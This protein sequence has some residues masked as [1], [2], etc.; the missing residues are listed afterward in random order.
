VNRSFRVAALLLALI[1]A[2]ASL[3]SA[4]QA[5][6]KKAASAQ[7]DPLVGQVMVKLRDATAIERVQKLGAQRVAALSKTAGLALESVRPMS[8]DATVMRLPAAMPLSQAQA[9][10]DRL[11]ADPSVEWAA[12]DLPVRRLQT[13]VPPDQGYATLQWNLFPPTTPFTSTT[14]GGGS[15][16]FIP[17]GG[18]NLPPAWGITTG[19]STITVAVID[20]GVVGSQRDLAGRLLPGF[21]FISSSALTSLGVPENFVANDGNGRDADASDPGDWV[22]ANEKQLYPT[23]CADGVTGDTP[24]SWHGTHMAGIIAALWGNDI[25]PTTGQLYPGTRIA[26]IGPGL[27]ILPVRALGKCGGTSS[28]VIDAMRWAAGLP[29]SSTGQTWAA[30]GIPANTSPA[31]VINLS[32]GGSPIACT[33]GSTYAPVVADVT[34]AGVTIVA[35]SGNDGAIGVLSPANCPGVIAVT[36]HVINGD[37]ADYSNV[38]PEVAI[39]AP[40]GGAPAFLQVVPNLLT[41]DDAYLIWSTGLFGATTPTSTV[42][43]TDLRSGDALVGVTGTSPAT[44]HVSAAVALMLSVNPGLTT[45]NIRGLLAASA[46]PHPTGGYCLTQQ[47]LNQC[48]AGLLDVGVALQR[49][50]PPPPSGGGGGGS[51][52][53]WPVLLM[54]ALGLA[55]EVR[56]RPA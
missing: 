37:N 45:A 55:R 23:A 25:D 17:A 14:V 34:A 1:G 44:P 35:A 41:T 52:P 18:A 29:A 24:S 32:L 47:G 40:G 43:S 22:T 20:T 27:R 50:V 28:D 12:P 5:P 9:V 2:A 30:L 33:A 48:G 8:G 31:K 39:S 7:R 11:R 16:T 26:G 46:R 42:S 56:R 13:Q 54:F 36:A 51:L 6:L 19:S 53:L 49:L 10:I 4:A 21:D 3:P 38:G 15:K